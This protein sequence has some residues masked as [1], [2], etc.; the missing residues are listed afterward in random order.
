[1]DEVDNVDDDEEADEEIDE[2]ETAL[3][4]GVVLIG[5][6]F[7]PEATCEDEWKSVEGGEGC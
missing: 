1:M 5:D 7:V 4:K 2:D 3:G 6:C